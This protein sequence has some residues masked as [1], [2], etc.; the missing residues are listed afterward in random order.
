MPGQNVAQLTNISTKW[1]LV[2]V[3]LILI[4]AISSRSQAP[5]TTGMCT[6]SPQHHYLTGDISEHSCC[7]GYHGYHGYRESLKGYVRSTR[8]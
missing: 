5:S 8:S 4:V 2:H 1:T 3:A 6:T 7:Y